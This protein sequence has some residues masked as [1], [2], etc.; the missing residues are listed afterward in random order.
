MKFFI[1]GITTPPLPPQN[2]NGLSLEELRQMEDTGRRGVE[3][4]LQC[5]KNIHTLMDA[6]VILMQQYI[7]A[8]TIAATASAVNLGSQNTTNGATGS[9]ETTASTSASGVDARY[10]Q[11]CIYMPI[12]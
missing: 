3:A 4:R 8:S 10:F 1:L 12:F 5:L 11:F 9:T 2:W 6:S 7:T